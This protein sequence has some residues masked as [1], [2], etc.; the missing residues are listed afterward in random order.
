M[1]GLVLLIATGYALAKNEDKIKGF[2]AGFISDLQ[3]EEK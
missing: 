1:I 3:K 2:V